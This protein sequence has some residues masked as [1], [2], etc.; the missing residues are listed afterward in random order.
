MADLT[1]AREAVA[2]FVRADSDKTALGGTSLDPVPEDLPA[3]VLEAFHHYSGVAQESDFGINV[4]RFP[5]GVG[6]LYVVMMVPDGNDGCFEA[7]TAAGELVGAGQFVLDR[8]AWAN[9]AEV[10]AL[11]PCSFLPALQPTLVWEAQPDGNYHS[12]CGRF[13]INRS[14]EHWVLAE[15]PV[16][17]QTLLDAQA[18]AQTLSPFYE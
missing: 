11:P 2:R 17:G 9:V 12:A 15:E 5:S 18:L 3:A 14:G 6:P 8:V 7:F 1:P 4:Y 13:H 10:R 16:L